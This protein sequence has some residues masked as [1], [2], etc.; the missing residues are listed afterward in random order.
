[1]KRKTTKKLIVLVCT[2]NTCRSP[3]AEAVFKTF[4]VNEGLTKLKI[5]SAGLRA[6]KGDALNPKSAQIL[7]EA[8][9]ELPEFKPARLTPAMLRQSFAVVCMTDSQRDLVME[10][11][12]QAFKDTET[13]VEELENNVYSFSELAGYE[14]LDPYGKDIDCYRY[15]YRLIENAKTVVLHKLVPDNMRAKFKETVKKQ[16]GTTRKKKTNDFETKEK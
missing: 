16:T 7:A 10:M 6:K 13:D 11:R 4:A 9:L 5:R 2:G 14:V 12:W 3:M 15:V 8:G 1:M